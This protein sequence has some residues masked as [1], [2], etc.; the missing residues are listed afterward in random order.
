MSDNPNQQTAQSSGFDSEPVKQDT[1]VPVNSTSVTSTPPV[2]S[3][4][5]GFDSQP[6]AKDTSVQNGVLQ[7]PEEI[8]MSRDHSIG[9]GER[10][11]LK[12]NPKYKY[13]PADPKFRNRPAGIYPD[14]VC[15]EQVAEQP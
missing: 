1:A 5:S 14:P 15:R 8:A 13:V 2:T 12:N 10:Q 11:F 4:D 9:A 6:V 7:T 3:A